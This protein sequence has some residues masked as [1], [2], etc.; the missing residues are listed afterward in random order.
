MRADLPVLI[1]PK[2]TISTRPDS[3]FSDMRESASRSSLSVL[4]S[5]SLQPPKRSIARRT[6]SSALP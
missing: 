4:R 5:S 2:T 1:S 6:E 3:S